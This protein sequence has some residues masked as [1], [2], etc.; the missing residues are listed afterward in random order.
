MLS[1]FFGSCFKRSKPTVLTVDELLSSSGPA[2]ADNFKRYKT[3]KKIGSG[4]FSKVWK[5][6]DTHTEQEVAMK[7]SYSSYTNSTL[8]KEF[9][10]LRKMDNPHVI[11]PISF[12]YDRR[13]LVTTHMI[14]PFMKKDLYTHAVDEKR[15]MNDDDLRKLVIDI[16]D[17]IKHVHDKDIVHRD[18]KIENI[19][20]DDNGDYILSD[21]GSAE[22]V[23]ALSLNELIGSLAYM[24]PE[25]AAV[26][27]TRNTI[28]TFA[29][30]KPIDI[31]SFGMTLYNI[32]T[33]T[34]GG[35]DPAN[36]SDTSFI[37][38]ISRF[39]MMPHIDNIA[40]R[41]VAFKDLLKRMLYRSP[42]A[43]IT[44]DEILSHDFVTNILT[45]TDM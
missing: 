16:A 5:A 21:F 29:I 40:D 6:V 41:S 27:V 26:H 14:L 32:V 18:I 2:M 31:F 1:C 45:N 24:A 39:D 19:L 15:Y 37:D 25:V 9:F 4:G 12:Y 33:F 10:I 3:I 30:G 44:I 42:V 43:R 28:S 7:V 23:N 38:E 17:A 34:M 13:A 8:E 11:S 22:D 20:I 35:A 36:K